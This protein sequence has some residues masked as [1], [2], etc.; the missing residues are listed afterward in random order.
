MERTACEL[1]EQ[2]AQD[3][4][5]A[6]F[7]AASYHDTT[8]ADAIAETGVRE[9]P[10]GLFVWAVQNDA[11]VPDITEDD[12]IFWPFLREFIAG[13]NAYRASNDRADRA[14]RADPFCPYCKTTIIGGKPERMCCEATLAAEKKAVSR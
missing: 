2:Q 4:F 7:E 10:D 12:A 8:H 13:V 3:A 6:G 1:T 11:R 14:D 9:T 5:D